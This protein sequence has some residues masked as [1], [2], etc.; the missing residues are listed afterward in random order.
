[1]VELHYFETGCKENCILRKTT[2]KFI[3]LILRIFGKK[4]ILKHYVQKY[5]QMK[6]S[7]STLNRP[8]RI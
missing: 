6:S 8:A 2:E 7:R 1:M 3:I 4:F 5:S